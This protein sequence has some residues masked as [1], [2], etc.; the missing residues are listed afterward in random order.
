M[1]GNRVWATFTFLE[2][3]ETWCYDQPPRN[4]LYDTLILFSLLYFD[5]AGTFDTHKL[6]M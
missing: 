3:S 4:L 5:F 6:H 2:A 1:L